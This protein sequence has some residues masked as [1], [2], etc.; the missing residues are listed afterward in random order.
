MRP[1]ITLIPA[2]TIWDGDVV[3]LAIVSVPPPAFRPRAAKPFTTVLAS[4]CHWATRKTKKPTRRT[5]R[6]KAASTF[7]FSSMAQKSA[8]TVMLMMTRV[9]RTAET[10]PWIR[11]KPESTWVLNLFRK[12]SRTFASAVDI[13]NAPK[14]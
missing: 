12:S 14:P 9:V 4:D 13:E 2:P 5:L 6:T 11:P 1:E 10:S 7:W 3:K 8:V